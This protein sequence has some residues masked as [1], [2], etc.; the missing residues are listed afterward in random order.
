M[1]PVILLRLG[2]YLRRIYLK[3]NF[4]KNIVAIIDKSQGNLGKYWNNIPITTCTI[5]KEK[6]YQNC[7]L[8]VTFALYAEEIKQEIIE[9]NFQGSVLTVF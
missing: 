9:M 6:Q 1:T 4:P 5:L 7:A 3:D 8:I 2:S